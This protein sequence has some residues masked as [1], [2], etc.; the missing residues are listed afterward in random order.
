MERLQRIFS[1]VGAGGGGM[2]GPHPDAPLVDSSEQVYISSLALLKML[3]HGRAGVPM[4]VMGLMLGEFVDEYT[5]RVVDVFAMPQSGT[6]VSVEAVDP[7]FQTNMLDMLKQTGRP[8]MVVG[9]YHSHPGFGCWL[10]GVDINTQQSFEALNQRS[11]AVVVDPIQSVKG[12]VVIDAFRLINPQTMM[13]GQEPRQ[14]TSNLG[15][16]NKPSIQALIHGLNR[17]YYSIGINYRKNEL[18]EKMLLNLH[19]KKWTDGLT[20]QR[21]DNHAKTNEATVQEMLELAVKYNKAVQEEDQLSPE[22]L[23]IA[24]VGRQDAKKHL[25]EHVSN[26]MSSNIVQTLGTML[27]TVVF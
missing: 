5:V 27:D 12:K 17:H 22:K 7:V 3:K 15:H 23:A 25:E 24:N 16:L 20:L 6:G 8:E 26:L 1:G 9:W 21:F 14:T 10:S 13:L 19:K 18:E 11:V 4:E 2:G